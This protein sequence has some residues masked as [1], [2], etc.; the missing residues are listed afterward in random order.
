MQGKEDCIHRIIIVRTWA[1]SRE[2]HNYE[3]LWD[4]AEKGGD[5]VTPCY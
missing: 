1:E 2:D 5:S 3:P 4:E